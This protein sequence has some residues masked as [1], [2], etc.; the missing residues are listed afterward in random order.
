VTTIAAPD[1][2]PAAGWRAMSTAPLAGRIDPAVVWTGEELLVLG[3]TR[4]DVAEPGQPAEALTSDGRALAVTRFVDGAAYDPATD[5][6][7]TIAPAPAAGL[8]NSAAWTGTRL[9]VRGVTTLPGDRPPEAAVL[10]YDPASDAWTVFPAPSGIADTLDV[11]MT[12][13]GDEL[14]FW[15]HPH[16][17]YGDPPL[18][19]ALDPATGAWRD[20]PAGPLPA[21]MG[22]AAAWDGDQVVVVSGSSFV[23]TSTLPSTPVAGLDPATGAWR[24]LPDAPTEVPLVQAQL[25][26]TGHQLLLA[27][28]GVSQDRNAAILAIDL[29]TEQWAPVGRFDGPPH[30]GEQWVW[31]GRELIEAS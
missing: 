6:W 25:L 3:G 29:Q 11:T 14:V 4:D 2:V 31:T 18:A 28:G 1:A 22:P 16:R 8:S 30:S 12:W 24:R 26:A 5:E 15:G 10:A 23:H 20:L 17:R 9:L 27:G 13:T 7:R 19:V 21:G